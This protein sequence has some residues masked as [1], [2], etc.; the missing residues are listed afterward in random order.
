M[1]FPWRPRLV[2]MG[3]RRLS[4]HRLLR[5]HLTS[6]QIHQLHQHLILPIGTL[7]IG[8]EK[9]TQVDSCKFAKHNINISTAPFRSDE[10]LLQEDNSLSAD[11]SSSLHLG[12][13]TRQASGSIRSANF[14]GHVF[15]TSNPVP[16]NQRYCY[17]TNAYPLFS[18]PVRKL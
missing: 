12:D 18:S 7:I 15:A 4:I 13:A 11:L 2:I 9:H 6:H 5:T 14:Q 16:T 1:V 17:L 3:N 10:S 8:T